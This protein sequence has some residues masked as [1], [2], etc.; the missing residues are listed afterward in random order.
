MTNQQADI[1]DIEQI[2]NDPNSGNLNVNG[3]YWDTDTL[4]WTKVTGTNSGINITSI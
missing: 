1:P 3:Y 2:E 4:A